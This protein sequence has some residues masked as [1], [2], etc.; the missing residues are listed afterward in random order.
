MK[1]KALLSV[2]LVLIIIAATA[3]NGGGDSASEIFIASA[4]PMTGDSA[5]F[6]DMKVKAIE[7]ALDEI[8]E[9]GGIDGK[10][11]KL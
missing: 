7:L 11:V 1:R 4:N 3:C 10:N 8:N 6:G 2:L 9:E 5:Q